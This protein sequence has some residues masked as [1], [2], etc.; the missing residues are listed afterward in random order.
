MHEPHS[1][2]RRAPLHVAC[3]LK[4]SKGSP[5]AGQTLDVG[6]GG[7]RVCT[8]RPLRIDEVV[9]FDLPIQGEHVDG[10]ARVLREQGFQVYALRFEALEADDAQRLA[11]STE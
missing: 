2:R 6:V 1:S 11:A 10:Q 3:T 5:I 8:E 9:T 4:R 7:M